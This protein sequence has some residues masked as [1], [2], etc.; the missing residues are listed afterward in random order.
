MTKRQGLLLALV[1]ASGSTLLTY[2]WYSGRQ[3]PAGAVRL[4]A[5]ARTEDTS[6]SVRPAVERTTAAGIAVTRYQRAVAIQV[7]ATR[8]A[9]SLARASDHVDV[10]LA[11]NDANAI[12]LAETILQDVPVLGPTA[13]QAPA[14]PNAPK[15]SKR[16][17][18]VSVSPQD[19]QRLVAAQVK[20]TL[21]VTLRNPVDHEFAYVR[22]TPGPPPPPGAPAPAA[23]RPAP[24]RPAGPPVP[25]TAKPAPRRAPRPRPVSMASLGMP[26]ERV[27]PVP[28]L[29]PT[30]PPAPAARAVP[31]PPPPS[32]RG[33][34]PSGPRA[35]KVIRGTTVQF[36][37]LD[38]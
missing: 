10:V 26:P 21:V 15:D 30:G 33:D 28:M 7:D 32:A 24:P 31:M 5:A 27:A 23:S 12:R 16:Q 34:V 18:V 22:P 6:V 2:I 19:A 36:V 20:G 8:G 29:A 37:T 35:V 11:A 4:P 38:K 9:G 1:L 14:D 25:A 3:S 17:L 13:Q